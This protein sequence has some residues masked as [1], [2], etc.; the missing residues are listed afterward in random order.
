MSPAERTRR[1][2]RSA[3]VGL[4]VLAG[5]LSAGAGCSTQT[6]PTRVT[7]R[8]VAFEPREIHLIAGDE[9]AWFYDDGGTFHD[10]VVE[11]VDGNAGYRAEGEHRMTFA[12]PGVYRVTCS[13]HPQM[14]GTVVV[15]PRA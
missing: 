11:G 12:A 4:L 9:V 5:V 10:V 14:V 15:E 3:A 6:E 13:I 2:G 1:P 8:N 7:V